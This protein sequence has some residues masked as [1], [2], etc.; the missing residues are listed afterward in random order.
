MT[1]YIKNYADSKSY[2]FHFYSVVSGE[3]V[4]F[5]ALLTQL[6]DKFSPNWS[7]Q[8][9]F[10]RQDPIITFQGTERTIDVA[11]DVPSKS[12]NQ[13]KDNLV[14]LNK[15]IKFLYPGFSTQGSANTIS[16]SPLLRIKFANLIYDQSTHNPGYDEDEPNG[17]VC[18]INN[19]SHKFKFDG[20]AGWVDEENSAIPASFSVS[21]SAM[22][23]HTHDLGHIQGTGRQPDIEF[24]YFVDEARRVEAVPGGN[25][26]KPPQESPDSGAE[27]DAKLAAAWTATDFRV[28]AR[29]VAER[30]DGITEP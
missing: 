21:F 8:K 13:A 7:S 22:I 1:D 24:P 2:Y 4:K 26:A 17:L 29:G 12:V 25:G 15:L 16:A 9:V 19:F 23:L 3:H 10:G 30:I 6:D 11:F 27:H 20:T 28:T 18:G 5:P 14:K